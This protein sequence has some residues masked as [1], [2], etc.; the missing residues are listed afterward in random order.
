M[1]FAG[2]VYDGQIGSG[3]T[4]L[5]R[6]ALLAAGALVISGCAQK[7]RYVAKPES[8]RAIW[9]TRWDYRTPDDI[10]RIFDDVA[11][12][13]LNTILFQVRGEGTVMYPSRYEPWGR[14]F[15]GRD[16]GF[17]PLAVA[18][19]EAH[20]RGLSLHAWINTMPGWKGKKPPADPRQLY[21][22]HPDWFLYDRQ[23]RRQPLS[24]HYVILNPALPE[25]RDYIAA[26]CREI[27][28]GYDI[29]GLHLDYIRFVTD[30]SGAGR[31]YPYDHR[32]VA[33]YRGSMGSHPDQDPQRWHLWRE[34][35][36]TAVVRE[37]R[38][39]QRQFK[40][41]IAL[42]AAVI[43]DRRRARSESFQN[44]EAWLNEGLVDA[45][46]PMA[47]RQTPEE[48]ARL[49]SDWRA[50]AHG[51]PVVP[52]IGIY[53]HRSDRASFDQIRMAAQWGD[54]FALFAY[55]SLFDQEGDDAPRAARRL[56]NLAPLLKQLARD[57]Q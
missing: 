45:I 7:E 15:G 26:V 42:T 5:A 54:G 23:G 46:L 52:G 57:V 10:A 8:P 34:Q 11:G 14:E 36:V 6:S 50:H 32:T 47:Y 27:I 12:I 35:Q 25:V 40:P 38:Q 49:I 20:R 16:P 37:I 3:A 17:D 13:G 55:S 24:A 51:E 4:R 22:A 18:V 33:R 29:D 21:N 43:G 39:T 19:A 2:R 56:R 53:N 48:F 30:E 28:G 44:A 41:D 31:D 1:A 9:V